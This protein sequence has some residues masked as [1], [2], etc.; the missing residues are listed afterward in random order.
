MWRRFGLAALAIGLHISMAVSPA[1]A[2]D[3]PVKKLL[4]IG[5]DGCRFDALRAAK[6]P[7]LDR[8]ID[9]G[10]AVEPIR[11]F[12]ARYREA[13]TISG[14]GW[15]SILCGVW[16]DKHGVMDNRF[17]SPNYD[18][19]PHFFVLLKRAQPDAVTA[20][21][22][23]WDMI[24]KH[25]TRAAD[26]R[27]HFPTDVIG[28]TAADSL[29]AKEAS[30]SLR[31]GDATATFVYFGQVDESGHAHGFHP[32]VPKYT[33]AIE[34]VDGHIGDLLEAIAERKNAANEDWLVLVTSDHGGKGTG[35]GGGHDDPE[36]AV[37]FIIA[38]GKALKGAKVSGEYGLVDVVPTGLAHLG[39]E[40]DPSW[41]LDGKGIRV[42][43]E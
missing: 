20:T 7:N 15:S 21:F 10:V 32:S 12:P 4:V 37:S 14:P 1:S 38:S 27:R 24:D 3:G 22:S 25:I 2:A 30:K 34:R 18:K 28:Y 26:V 33:A 5:I 13:D 23:D 9:E 39:V 16:S 35:H 8:L 42:A 31:E 17:T 19:F 36:V 41:G 40:I 29:I 6:T 43:G 11:I